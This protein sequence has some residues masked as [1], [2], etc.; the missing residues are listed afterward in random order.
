MYNRVYTVAQESD[1]T[2]AWAV[3][4][5]STWEPLDTG[6]TTNIKNRVTFVEGVPYSLAKCT[7]GVRHFY[8]TGGLT[9]GAGCGFNSTTATPYNG[10]AGANESEYMN[11]IAT[12]SVAY[13]GFGVNYAQA[14][15]YSSSTSGAFGGGAGPAAG[16]TVDLEM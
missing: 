14:M 9:I 7:I 10:M 11:W 13:P 5:A 12:T 16:M 1:S 4:T 8:T 15:E 6:S 2:A 3:H